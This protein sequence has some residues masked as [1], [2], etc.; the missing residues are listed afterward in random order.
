MCDSRTIS[1]RVEFM[2]QGVKRQWI[3]AEVGNVKYSFSKRKV[4]T[5]K[6]GV[7]SCIW[8][9]EI[10]NTS[11]RTDAGT[12]LSKRSVTLPFHTYPTN[13]LP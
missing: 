4:K 3:V 10:G 9:T 2:R 5:G 12:C 7:E 13:V 6:I 8:R 11:G 1:P